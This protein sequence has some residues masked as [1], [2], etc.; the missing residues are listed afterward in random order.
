M[1]KVYYYN[2]NGVLKLTIG[3]AP[4]YMLQGT[5]EFKNH[6]WGYDSQ[7]GR[8]RNFRREK[9]TYPFSVAVISDDSDDFDRLCDIFDEDVL[10]G[11]PGYFLI[12]GW[13]LECTVITA[14]HTFFAKRDNVI[15]FEAVSET[16][17]WIRNK[18]TS[19][20]GTTGGGSASDE[21]LGRDYTYADG[22]LGRDYNYGYNQPESH[23]ASI[24][25]AGTGN[26]YEI[27]IY[28]PQANPVIY[29]NDQ[30]VKV[31]ITIDA[32]ERLQIVSNGSIKTIKVLTPSGAE[33]DAFVFR[34]KE[35]SPFLQLGQ[36][37]D[38]TYGQI[39][40]DFTSIERRSEP[41]WT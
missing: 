34:D 41:T 16:S 15:E 7:F 3:E 22:I 38:L 27:M 13:K 12:N 1:D 18:T 39:R 4:Y 10:A 28:G 5:G 24:D 19:H 35:N 8:H 37:T 20:N 40:F 29:L 17:A 6:I 36:H 2:R 21:D 9:L 33:T 26:G 11:E 23:Y 31:N 14:K 25:L 30:P 32:T